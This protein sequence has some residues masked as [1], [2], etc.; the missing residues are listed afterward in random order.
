[1]KK[2][3]TMA[4]IWIGIFLGMVIVAYAITSL[5]FTGSQTSDLSKKEIF[6]FDLDTGLT[7]AEIGSGD[8]FSVAP[9]IYNDETEEMYMFV[10]V[11]MPVYT[12][13]TGESADS[14]LYTY[15]VSG[16][17]TLVESGSETAVYAYGSGGM[18][19][20]YLGESTT[21]LTN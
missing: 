18:T 17:W 15:D 13:S 10:K 1:M 14:L 11:Q 20:L 12:D 16:D 7:S 19:T 8:I 21:A 9:V 4:G 5:F 6:Q 2:R 3:I